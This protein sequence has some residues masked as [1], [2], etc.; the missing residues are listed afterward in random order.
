MAAWRADVGSRSVAGRG[1]R[2]RGPPPSAVRRLPARGAQ[3]AARSLGECPG[4]ARGSVPREPRRVV[5]H[6]LEAR[7]ARKG[8]VGN[9]RGWRRLP[10]LQRPGRLSGR[11]A[12]CGEPGAWSPG[13]GGVGAAVLWPRG[14]DRPVKKERA[15]VPAAAREEHR[16]RADL[17][18]FP[19]GVL[20][21]RKNSDRGRKS[22]RASRP[23]RPGSASAGGDLC[24]CH[25]WPSDLKARLLLPN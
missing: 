24:G 16:R 25:L 13:D 15:G 19:A 22:P 1:C 21:I 14:R 18:P 23:S 6:T 5:T 8:S 20:S 3:G 12:A 17:A 4:N 9:G 2:P 7:A 10:A 11:E